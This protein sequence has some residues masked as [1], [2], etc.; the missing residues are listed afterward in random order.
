VGEL[1]GVEV[2]VADQRLADERGEKERAE[3]QTQSVC[4]HL[5]AQEAERA[6]V[7]E[8]GPDEGEIRDEDGAHQ[9]S[10]SHV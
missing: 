3:G 2:S 4:A 10:S 5:E 1:D 6:E 8:T 7:H 9:L